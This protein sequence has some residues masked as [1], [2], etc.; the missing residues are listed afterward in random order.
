MRKIQFHEEFVPAG[1]REKFLPP[2]FNGNGKRNEENSGAV[3]LEAGLTWMDVYAAAMLDRNLVTHNYYI[4]G[5]S[6]H[7]FFE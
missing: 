2:F 6:D 4:P 5:K 1:R 7:I 3:T